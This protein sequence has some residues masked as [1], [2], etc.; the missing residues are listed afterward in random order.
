[1]PDAGRGFADA[2][3]PSL[4]RRSAALR[5][6]R[7]FRGAAR[8]VGLTCRSSQKADRLAEV[9]R[10][11]QLPVRRPAVSRPV[12]GRRPRRLPGGGVHGAVRS[13]SARA[14]APA[15]RS[16]LD[17]G[18][19][20]PAGRRLGSGAAGPRDPAGAR[21]R[22]PRRPSRARST[23]PRRSAASGSTASP[24]SRR[25]TQTPGRLEATL[26]DNLAFAADAAGRRGVRL[27]A[28]AD[29]LPRHARFL[30]QP[31][32]SRRCG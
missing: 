25:P 11:P 10:Q 12:R 5:S 14:R 22:V 8:Q 29:Q 9:L 26:L 24:A 23:T 32:R 27:L 17:S 13:R 2:A 20:Q 28:R 7:L 19:V 16:R 15:R 3:L 4:G 6:R 30:P 1:M 21:R 18:A 31:D